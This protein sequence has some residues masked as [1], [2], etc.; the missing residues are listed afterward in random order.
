MSIQY[1]KDRK[2]ISKRFTVEAIKDASANML[3]LC[4][5]CGA[6]RD[7]CEPDARCY[8]CEACGKRL[9][10]GSEEILIMGLVKS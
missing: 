3:G 2:I 5:A 4:L 7:C 10:Y 8:P 6:E 9:V 1:T